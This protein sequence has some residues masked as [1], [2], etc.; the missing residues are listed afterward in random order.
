MARIKHSE[1]TKLALILEGMKGDTSIASLCK[2]YGVSD[3][4][5]Y[6]WRD[7]FVEGGKRALSGKLESPNGELKRKVSTY[8]NVIGRLTIQNEILKKTFE[9]VE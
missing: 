5:Y 3:A 1:E 4:M 8:E 7:R 2:K 6:K 9:D